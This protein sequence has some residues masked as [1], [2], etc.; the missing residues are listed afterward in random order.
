[1]ELEGRERRRFLQ[2]IIGSIVLAAAG[3]ENL[4]SLADESSMRWPKSISSPVF[5][6]LL[7][8]VR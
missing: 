5:N 4:Q 2:R 7:D 8:A 3:G 1:M 6:C